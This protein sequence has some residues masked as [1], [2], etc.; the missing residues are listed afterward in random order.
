LI[1]VSL[2]ILAVVTAA[3]P[4]GA[5]DLASTRP[6]YAGMSSERLE[7]L[8]AAMQRYV[9]EDQLAGAVVQVARRGRTVY[10]EAFGRLDI[11]TSVP[12]NTDAIFRIAS[13]TKAVISVGVMILQ[14]EGRLLIGSPVGRYLPEYME[15]T[16]AVADDDGGYQIVEAERPITIRDLLTHTAGVGYGVGPAADLWR[17]AGIQG[18][19]FANRD[20]PIRQTV[21]RIASLPFD[22][23]PGT[24][25]VYGYSTDIL[26]A[27]MT[28][29]HL[30]EVDFPW[31]DG[32]GFGLGFSTLDDLGAFGAPGTVGEY[33]WGGA[34]HSTYWVDPVE[35][36]VVVYFTQL[37]PALKIDDHGKLRALIYQAIMD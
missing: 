28:V 33:G 30:G 23:Q 15:T 21:E 6:E 2:T 29:S 22:A 17:E 8:S 34:Y 13:Q 27:L 26:G 14:E 4:A 5:Q 31:G 7:R 10:L 36:L 32:T 35:E 16:V 12:M 25:F 3:A 19:Y 11:E 9:D 24:Q 18:W 20:E 1:A 37:N